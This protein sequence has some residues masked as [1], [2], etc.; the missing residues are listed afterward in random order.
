MAHFAK[1]DENN[2]VLT[3]I[4]VNNNEILDSNGVESEQVGIEWCKKW[5]GGH[6]YWKQASYNQ[7]IRKWFPAYDGFTY[8][9]QRDAFI[10]PK[11]FNSWVLDEEKYDWVAPIPMPEP[12]E[13]MIWVWNESIVNWQ[14][15]KGMEI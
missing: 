6:P 14:S 2:N 9:S 11:P 7:K 13:G 12:V 4:V 5:S 3:V 15:L 1:L 10:P 8:D